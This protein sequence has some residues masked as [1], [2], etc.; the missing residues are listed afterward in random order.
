MKSIKLMPL[1]RLLFLC[2]LLAT[3]GFGCAKDGKDHDDEKT[4][5]QSEWPLFQYDRGN[6]GLSPVVGPQTA[7]LLWDVSVD[8]WVSGAVIA[9]DGRIY[10]GDRSGNVLAFD[11]MGDRKK[12]TTLPDRCSAA[13]ESLALSPDGNTIYVGATSDPY[14]NSPEPDNL[15]LYA[16]SIEGVEQFFY[17]TRYD[18]NGAP[19]VGN[20]GTIYFVSG[21]ALHAVGS[22]GKVKWT[23]DLP[24][25]LEP[26]AWSSPAIGKDGTI[27][28]AADCLSAVNQDG[29]EKWIYG[30]GQFTFRSEPSVAPNG[31]IYYAN[32][33]HLY[34]VNPDG[35][36]KWTTKIGYTE[37]S[38]SIGKKAIYMGG[39]GVMA[40]DLETGD[41]LWRFDT[42]GKWVDASTILGADETIYV[43]SD[44]G[45]FYALNPDGTEKWKVD[46]GHGPPSDP[47]LGEVDSPAILDAEGTLFFGHAG[48]PPII[49]YHFYAIRD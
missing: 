28:I 29:T 27:Y 13:S 35:T 11:S 7:T 22:D 16:F 48:G 6:T 5:R 33:D 47:D 1:T 26:W 41:L 46:V 17:E 39:D 12:I 4:M 10:V 2:F 18:C 9:S 24:G 40:L 8:D 15:G 44:N 49:G 37:S 31:T 23:Y 30:Q 32:N 14:G 42:E 38:P 20:D 21:A 34:A 36:E 43:G 19:N 3:F 25:D 45:Y